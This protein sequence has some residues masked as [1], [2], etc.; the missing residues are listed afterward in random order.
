M[1]KYN[2]Q[3]KGPYKEAERIGEQ[4]SRTMGVITRK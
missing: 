3:R 1:E 2:Y 4:L